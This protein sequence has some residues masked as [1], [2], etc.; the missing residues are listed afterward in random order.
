MFEPLSKLL[1]KH[2]TRLQGE[3]SEI[4]SH[5]LRVVE[6]TTAKLVTASYGDH[7]SI[8]NTEESTTA[9]IAFHT[10]E[11]W[12]WKVLQT[13]ITGGP[14]GTCAIYLHGINPE[15]LI[16]VITPSGINKSTAEYLIPPRSRI[17]F[18]F[19]EQPKNQTCTVHMQVERL[20]VPPAYEVTHTRSFEHTSDDKPL[21]PQRPIVPRVPV[22]RGFEQ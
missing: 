13:A 4:N 20:V 9:E 5:L 2:G 11:G 19:Y 6:N 7:S 3:L 16:D 1:D 18:H 8:A 21:A 12:Y 15:S 14:E 17:F 22:G 10:A